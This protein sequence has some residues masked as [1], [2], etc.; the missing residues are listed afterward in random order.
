MEAFF[1]QVVEVKLFQ[2]EL[3]CPAS[4]RASDSMSSTMPERSRLVLN[5]RQRL[6]V[7]ARL[8]F[9]RKRHIGL[10]ANDRQ[11]R[12]QFV[13]RVGGKSPHAVERAFDPRQ[14]IVEDAR[15][16]AQFVVLVFTGNPRAGSPR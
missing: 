3:R 14:Q 16:F 13:R 12:P 7:F 15:Q 6:A 11:R 9:L 10:A 4:A 1:D 5:D 2:F 8:A